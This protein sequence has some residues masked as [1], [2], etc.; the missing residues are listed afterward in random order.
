M[1]PNS[2]LGHEGQFPQYQNQEEQYRFQESQLQY[3]QQQAQHEL[4][5]QAQ[6]ELQ[7]Q[8]LLQQQQQQQQ[9]ALQKQQQ[10][11]SMQQQQRMR[12]SNNFEAAMAMMAET[13]N[14]LV[15]SMNRLL[16]K[17]E[18]LTPQQ[19]TENKP[20]R[21]QP[22][23][24]NPQQIPTQT[25]NTSEPSSPSEGAYPREVTRHQYL[26][27]PQIRENLKF[28][29]ESR[30]LRQFLLDIYDTLGRFSNKFA[31][32]KRRINW[33]AGHFASN[34]NE[35]SP[36]QAWFLALLM[37]NAHV[38]GVVDPYADLKSLDY[39]LPPLRSKDAF[40]KELISVFGDKTS[41]KTARQDLSK[42]KQGNNPIV[43]YNAR[44]TSLALYVV[45]SEEDAILKY[46]AGLNPEV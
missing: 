4:H 40:I 46:V 9:E 1:D 21:H 19:P 29:G 30:F 12:D 35:V 3:Q 41:S 36:A 18:T 27:E 26:K 11:E 2:A 20:A 13:Q 42:C 5:Q 23:H 32:D 37:K 34:T 25:K 10:Q 7:Q 38:H 14:K 6:H 8:Q 17:F 43:D 39:I 28:T 15:E 24:L 33:I 45:Q 16:T 44:Y 22:P 31:N